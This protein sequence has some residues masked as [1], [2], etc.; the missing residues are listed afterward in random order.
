MQ[1]ELLC[2][3]SFVC[4]ARVFVSQDYDLYSDLDGETYT[5]V[6]YAFREGEGVGKHSNSNR[7]ASNVNFLSGASTSVR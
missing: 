4:F 7:G 5:S 3:V 6:I 2:A 1:R